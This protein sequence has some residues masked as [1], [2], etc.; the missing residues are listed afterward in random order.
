MKSSP[1]SSPEAVFSGVANIFSTAFKRK[2]LDVL[3][4]KDKHIVADDL[5]SDLK[6]LKPDMV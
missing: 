4:A 5:K 2:G 3:C 6:D 1:K